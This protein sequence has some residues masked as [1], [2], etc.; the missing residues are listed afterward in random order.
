MRIGD[1]IVNANGHYLRGLQS[2]ERVQKLLN[3]F[4]GNF[5]D[6]VIAHD[7]ISSVSDFCTK[8]KIDCDEKEK[9]QN[10][11]QCYE[12]VIKKAISYSQRSHSSDS[13]SSFD[14]CHMRTTKPKSSGDIDHSSSSSSKSVMGPMIINSNEVEYK[15]VY[16]NNHLT[17]TIHKSDDEKLQMLKKDSLALKTGYR[18]SLRNSITHSTINCCTSRSHSRLSQ[19]PRLSP[20]RLSLFNGN[21]FK[22]DVTD[23]FNE[24]NDHVQAISNTLEKENLAGS[25]IAPKT[26]GLGKLLIIVFHIYLI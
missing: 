8:I 23:M 10:V 24:D 21:S 11:Q 25:I 15:P 3:N 4:I 7:E 9:I 5:I 20:S 18:P 16:A 19:P 22:I 26:Q 17:I 14:V 13:L 6:L 1:E 12:N 2:F